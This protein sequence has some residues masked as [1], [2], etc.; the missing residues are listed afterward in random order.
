MRGRRIGIGAGESGRRPVRARKARG[1]FG[2]GSVA[3][4]PV[5]DVLDA[6]VRV[7]DIGVAP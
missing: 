5:L 4:P 1:T 2:S 7:G 6:L 3:A